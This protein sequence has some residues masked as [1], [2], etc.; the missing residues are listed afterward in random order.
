V[1][2]VQSLQ[3]SPSN[4]RTCSVSA[5]EPLWN[6]TCDRSA[7]I[8]SKTLLA[9][10]A[11]PPMTRCPVARP[12]ARGAVVSSNSYLT[13]VSP[14]SSLTEN[15]Q[16]QPLTMQDRDVCRG[17]H[18]GERLDVTEKD[19]VEWIQIRVPC[20]EVPRNLPPVVDPLGIVVVRQFIEHGEDAAAVDKAAVEA[21]GLDRPPIRPV[22]IL[23][24]PTPAT[25][26]TVGAA[27]FVCLWR[28]NQQ[29]AAR[30]ETRRLA[31][32]PRNGR[33]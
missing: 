7:A 14:A 30:A 6:A 9:G 11:K 25:L 27:R 10:L 33:R 28:L 17:H 13:M 24:R 26:L 19:A 32:I 2:F 21:V 8:T 4:A 18:G 22:E 3:E 29:L 20:L 16:S 23:N 1:N 5:P 15:R 31:P 12:S